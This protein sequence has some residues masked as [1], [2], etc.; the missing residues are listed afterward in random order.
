MASKRPRILLIGPPGSGK[1][2]IANKISELHLVPFVKVGALLRNLL[3]SNANYVLINS[4]M[5]KGEL[6]PNNL[7]ALVVKEEIENL[8]EGFVLDGWL[9]QLS[10]MQEYYPEIDYVIFLN[11]PKK[12]CEERV[13]NRF[14]CKID[15]SIYSFTDTVCNLC[16]GKLEKRFDDTPETFEKRWNVYV[17]KT[18][19]VLDFFRNNGNLITIDAS[20]SIL[21]I[22]YEIDLKLRI[23]ND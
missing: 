1:T 19:P 10:D 9:R 13:L 7:V 22:V 23:L 14:I 8:K 18:T 4:A 15:N 12:I 17:E 6:A 3:P 16:G 2:A 11:C 21:E 20:K 5:E